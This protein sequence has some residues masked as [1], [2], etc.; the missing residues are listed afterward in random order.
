MTSAGTEKAKQ[1]YASGLS[2]VKI[3]KQLGRHHTVIARA[4]RSE[5]KRHSPASDHDPT[6]TKTRPE[7]TITIAAYR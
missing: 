4:L 2:L 1:L 7:P 6:D 3:G 5:D